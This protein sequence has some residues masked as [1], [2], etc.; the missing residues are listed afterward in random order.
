MKN[1]VN[2][3]H[4]IYRYNNDAYKGAD[5]KM[6]INSKWPLVLKFLHRL[7]HEIMIVW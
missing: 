2:T 5:K 6:N 1:I 3:K 4:F 7:F